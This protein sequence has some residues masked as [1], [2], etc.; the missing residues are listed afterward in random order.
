MVAR[1]DEDVIVADHFYEV[2]VLVDSIGCAAVPVGTAVALI[3]RQDV[4]AALGRVEVPRA[5][6]ADVPVQ[7][8]RLIL[9]QD[10]DRI[11]AGIAAVTQWEVDDA[12]FSAEQKARFSLVFGQDAQTASFPASQN[13]GQAIRFFIEAP[14]HLTGTRPLRLWFQYV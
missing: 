1:Q 10:A 4:R 13:H 6:V 7:F 12:I 11:D 2:Q 3:R 8:Q 14:P 5:A 9:G